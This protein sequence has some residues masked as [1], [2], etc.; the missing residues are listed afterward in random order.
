MGSSGIEVSCSTLE[1]RAG[2]RTSKLPPTLMRT[3]TCG[4]QVASTASTKGALFCSG[5]SPSS[6]RSRVNISAARDRASS[7]H[8]EEVGLPIRSIGRRIELSKFMTVTP[9]NGLQ[10][11]KTVEGCIHL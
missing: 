2:E 7:R 1:H 4:L 8:A 3:L 5:E 9:L 6:Q 10:L 11:P